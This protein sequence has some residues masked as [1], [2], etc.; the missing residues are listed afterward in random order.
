MPYKVAVEY[1]TKFPEDAFNVMEVI[2]ALFDH[3]PAIK[4]PLTVVPL[5]SAVESELTDLLLELR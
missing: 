2:A 5:F 4:K 1:W 3:K